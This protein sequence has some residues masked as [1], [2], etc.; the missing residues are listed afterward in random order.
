MASS[1]CSLADL[2]K[3]LTGTGGVI[4]LFGC[5]SLGEEVSPGAASLQLEIQL[6]QTPQPRLGF[7]P[8]PRALDQQKRLAQRALLTLAADVAAVVEY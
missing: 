5:L 4:G 7:Q 3:R 8:L 6:L 1:L 2:D